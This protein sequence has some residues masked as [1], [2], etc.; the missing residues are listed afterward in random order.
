MK[1]LVLLFLFIGTYA[2]SQQLSVNYKNT[3]LK[4]VILD[5]EAKT[6]YTFA[7]SENV[8][9][10]KTVS[11][12]NPKTTLDAV[13]ST[14]SRQTNLAFEKIT[15]SQ[16]LIS[17]PQQQIDVCG[18]LFDSRTKLPLSFASVIIKG[19]VRGTISEDNGYFKL[20]NID[21]SQEI[22]IEYVGYKTIT[23]IAEAYTTD[24]CNNIFLQPVVETLNEIIIAQYLT[25]GI[26]KQI[27]GSLTLQNDALGILT[28]QTEPDVFESLQAIPGITSMDE[29]ASGIQIR[30]GSADQN[31]IYFDNI[32]LYNTG[33]FFGMLSAINP[34]ITKTTKVYKGGAKPEY[35]DRISGVLD[36]KSNEKI[37]EKTEA[38]VGIN[39]THIDAFLNTHLGKDIGILISGRHSYTDL[40]QTPTFNAL[41]EKVFQN[42]KIT[43][44]T[45]IDPEAE[46]TEI[47]GDEKFFFYDANTKVI[48]HPSK[49]DTFT[50]SG[51]LTKNK[52]DFL[53][54]DDEDITKDILNIKNKGASF[55]WTGKKFNKLKHSLKFYYSDYDSDYEN[56]LT[57]QNILEEESLRQ[58]TVEDLGIAINLGYNLSKSHAITFGYQFS[59]TNV[60][61]RLFRNLDASEPPEPGEINDFNET[62]NTQNKA[63]S[64]YGE[65]MFTPKKKA[66]ISIGARNSYYSAPDSY[67]FEPRLN[68]EYPITKN[69]RLKATL[70]KRFQPISQLVEFEDVQLRL[71]NHVWTLSDGRE[72]PVIESNQYTGGFLV[73]FNDWLLDIDGYYK[74]IEGLTS[75]TNGFTNASQNITEGESNITGIDVLIRKKIKNFRVWLGYTFNDVEYTFNELQNTP[76]SGNNDITHNFKIS[77]TLELDSWEF[78]LGWNYR[79][80]APF[81]PVANFNP[82]T[83]VITFG[84]INSLRLPNYHRL[85]A[86]LLYK[87][88]FN[89]SKK[90]RGTLGASIRN[91]YAR[92]V[93]LS[94]FYRVNEN[95]ETGDNELDQLEQL[96]LGVTPN[97]S[98]RVNF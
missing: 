88:N 94:V 67:F 54:Q 93:P 92:Q 10:D 45:F 49:N 69:F 75:F 66:F 71:E 20:K 22:I 9:A 39:G 13:L 82:D 52:L 43:N 84:N 95:P 48:L 18:Y 68:A 25:K 96:S 26:S 6:K 11:L 60:F 50:F 4:A 61:F 2:F 47:V 27:D 17:L 34:Y 62:R 15:D 74:T 40:I 55:T 37:L 28:G 35:G 8:I 53:V 59:N 30:G 33:H 76:F 63:H 32:K 1:K 80:G 44:N 29:S 12:I 91:L 56:T 16:I 21:R 38:S 64:V 78:S 87:F 42:T 14:L 3:P 73:N 19:T 97:I 70:E 90:V 81:T 57:E 85:D 23:I 58:N 51:L 83:E 36:I 72:I 5:L 65:Y 98:F 79:T 24:N 86:S 31:L 89:S 7:Y 46:I 77:N 41:A